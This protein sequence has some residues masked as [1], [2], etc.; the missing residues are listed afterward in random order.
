MVRLIEKHFKF[1]GVLPGDLQLFLETHLPKPK[2]KNKDILGVIDPKLGASINEA[3]GIVCQHVGVVPEV[4]RGKC[5]AYRP[6]LIMHKDVRSY[7]EFTGVLTL[8]SSCD[9]TDR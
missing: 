6:L 1:S 3:L 8:S 7:F 9:M 4:I 2:G 5:N